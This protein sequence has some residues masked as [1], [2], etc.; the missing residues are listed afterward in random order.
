[1]AEAFFNAYSRDPK[2]R[3]RSA[4]LTPTASVNPVVVE[5]MKEKG[6]DVS[7]H[8]PRLLSAEDA[9]SA[10]KIFTM[11]CTDG[12]PVTPPE[13]TED[14]KLED[15]AGKLLADV[16]KIRDDVECRIHELLLTLD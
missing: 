14:W 5:A 13:K 6:I 10:E 9:Q 2:W 4:G 16:R 3:A 7:G 8:V 11:G 15:P 1:M 12:C